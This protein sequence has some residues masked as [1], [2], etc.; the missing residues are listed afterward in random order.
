M[1]WNYQ[2]EPV[3]VIL[4]WSLK[5]AFV[6]CQAS[7]KPKMETKYS[8]NEQQEVPTNPIAWDSLKNLSKVEVDMLLQKTCAVDQSQS[9]SQQAD[10]QTLKKNRRG[11]VQHVSP[12]PETHR[13]RLSFQGVGIAV[14]GLIGRMGSLCLWL[15]FGKTN[16]QVPEN[17]WE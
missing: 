4:S 11:N 15:K 17:Q 1:I 16:W 7:N 8:P 14:A 3:F 10:P 12:R 6:G 2:Q 9:K 13:T 5:M